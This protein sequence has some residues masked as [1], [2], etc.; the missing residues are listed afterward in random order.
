MPPVDDLLA[1][2][3]LTS[4]TTNGQV[5]AALVPATDSIA[6]GAGRADG[7]RSAGEEA[8]QALR[9]EVSGLRDALRVEQAMVASLVSNTK[10]DDV[11][12][13]EV[14]QA[15]VDAAVRKAVRRE[16][17][18]LGDSVSALLEGMRC[19]MVAMRQADLDNF[20]ALRE[21]VQQLAVA[22]SA[23]SD[24]TAALKE[25]TED[26]YAVL[27]ESL[28]DV[29]AVTSTIPAE[30]SRHS[31]TNRKAFGADLAEELQPIIEAVA[32][33]IAQS[34]YGLAAITERLDALAASADTLAET[35]AEMIETLA[36]PHADDARAEDVLASTTPSVAAGHFNR[37][38]FGRADAD[39]AGPNP[40]EAP[41]RPPIGPGLAR[42]PVGRVSLPRR[43]S[44]A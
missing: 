26:N 29:T 25:A 37:A 30:L 11:S 18:A 31:A 40:P 28:A 33:S 17:V 12:D 34:D 39:Q 2:P 42:P 21:S 19:D 22:N 3:T 43:H 23:L 4:T 20:A 1:A 13:A 32:E 15:A 35:V 24:R 6:A 9:N 27:K 10:T 38:R 36:D 16:S 41:P 7:L 5:P 14:L 44:E 8:L